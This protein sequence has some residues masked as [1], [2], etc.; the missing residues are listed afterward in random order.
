MT[1]CIK[2]DANGLRD[3]PKAPAFYQFVNQKGETLYGGSTKNLRQRVYQHVYKADPCKS[4]AVGLCWTPDLNPKAREVKCLNH[5]NDKGRL[6][7]CNIRVPRK[8]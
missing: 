3:L 8:A 4:D 6:P 2:L 1:Q 7:R 5:L